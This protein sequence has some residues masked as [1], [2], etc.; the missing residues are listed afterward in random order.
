MA[1]LAE[2]APQPRRS[3]VSTPAGAKVARARVPFTP[4]A[5]C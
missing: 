5:P 2:H 3:P 4:L 1:L